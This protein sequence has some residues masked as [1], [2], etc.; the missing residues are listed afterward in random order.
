MNLF[1]L[2]AGPF[3]KIITSSTS[4]GTAFGWVKNI[5]VFLDG[6]IVPVTIIVSIVGAIWIIWLG[7]NLA[8]A[9]DATKQKD[10]KSKLINVVVAIIAVIVLIWLLTW[11]S[12]SAGTIFGL[13]P[14]SS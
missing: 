9:E 3:E 4:W 5:A 6:I 2:L 11:F 7:V 8:K 1:S 13:N 10:A 12:S 14:I